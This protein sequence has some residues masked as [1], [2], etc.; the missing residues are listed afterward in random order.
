V[1][2]REVHR[3]IERYG[4]KTVISAFGESQAYVE[5]VVRRRLSGVSDGSWEAEDYIDND[6]GSNEGLV[7]IKVRM[8]ISGDRVQYDLSG[9]HPAI[10]SFLNSAFG[11]SYSAVIAGTKTFFPDVPLNSGFCRI[12]RTHRAGLRGADSRRRVPQRTAVAMP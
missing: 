1:C 2:E 6:P 5:R 4:Q 10:G 12:T 3:L 11:G 9:S 8:R 7:P